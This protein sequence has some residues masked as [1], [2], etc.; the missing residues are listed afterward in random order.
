MSRS[1]PYYIVEQGKISQLMKQSKAARLSLFQDIAGTKVYDERKKESEKI[2]KDTDTK[3][4][5]IETVIATLQER[6]AELEAESAEFNKY[7][8]RTSKQRHK[9][10]RQ[11]QRP[12]HE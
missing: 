10:E 9:A 11:Q 2:M 3:R 7:Q 8:V 12:R 1:N 4:E 5:H 6:L